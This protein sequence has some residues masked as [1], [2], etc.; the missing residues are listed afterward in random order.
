MKGRTDVEVDIVLQIIEANLF[1]S[2][3]IKHLS[4]WVLNEFID[5][6]LVR[7]ETIVQACLSWLFMVISL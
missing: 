2:L 4:S 5:D 6:F 3:E 1:K 7:T